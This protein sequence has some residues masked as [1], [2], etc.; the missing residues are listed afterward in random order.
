[1]MGPM[2]DEVVIDA[3]VQGGKPVLRGTRVTVDAVV[4][5]LA[6]GDDVATVARAFRL[7]VDQVRAALVYAADILG[8]ERAIAL[9]D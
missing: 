2:L 9:P 8:T 6:A 5:A 7:T 1:M 3:Q 4:R